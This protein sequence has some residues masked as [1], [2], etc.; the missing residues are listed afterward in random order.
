MNVCARKYVHMFCTNANMAIDTY[1]LSICSHTYSSCICV[2]F[3]QKRCAG[4]ERDRKSGRESE[5]ADIGGRLAGDLL[6]Q[7]GDWSQFQPGKHTYCS[8][9]TTQTPLPHSQISLGGGNT[10]DDDWS[11]SCQYLHLS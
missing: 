11:C 8:S 3:F 4:T 10:E 7:I 9:Q 5:L 6:H 2:Y 1:F